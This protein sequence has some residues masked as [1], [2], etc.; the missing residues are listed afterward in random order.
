MKPLDRTKERRAGRL[1][2]APALALVLLAPGCSRPSEGST[3]RSA[4][5]AE[6]RPAAVPRPARLLLTG[7]IAASRSV[8]LFVPETPLW[9][10]QVRWLAEE[11]TSVKAGDPVAEFDSTA[12]ASQLEQ[13]RLA[14]DEARTEVARGE[15]EAEGTAAERAF[16][17]EGRRVEVEKARLDA[18]IPVEL[19]SRR[20]HEE[21]QLALRRAEAEQAKAEESLRAA[22]AAA[23]ADRKVRLLAEEK[24]RRDLDEAERA[25][26][27][28]TLRAPRDGVVVV[29]ENPRERRKIQE[30]DNVWP[31]MAV[32]KIPDLSALR[33][34]ANL[35]DVDDGALKAGVPAA[36]WPD[37]FPER[38]L[39]ARVASVAP[40]AQP[41]DNE[42]PRAAFKVLLDV[43]GGSLEGL[44]PGMSVRVEAPA[45]APGAVAGPAG[46]VEPLP[47]PDPSSARSVRVA[48]EDL[49]VSVDLK[50]TLAALDGEQ[51]GPTRLPNVWQFRISRMAP[52]GSKVKKGQPVL[53]F[54]TSE[55]VQSLAEKRAEGESARKLIEKRERDLE[56]R[57]KDL[58]LARAEA[59]ARR[60]KAALKADVPDEVVD[61]I[62]LKKARLDLALAV[63]EV[64]SVGRRLAAAERA[65][66]AELRILGS[67]ER[68]AAGR[69]AELEDA[70][71][72]MSIP[73]PRD[74]TVL[75]VPNWRDEKKKV[76]DSCWVGEKVLEVPDLSRL[77][78]KGEVDE[79][80]AGR[81]R[82]GDRVTVRLDAHPDV[83]Y[84][85]KVR[86]IQRTVQRASPKVPL[87]VARVEVALDAVDEQRMRPGM[88]VRGRVELERVRR[89]L[90]V[91]LDCV[92]AADG[93]PVV[94]R[95]K[96][97]SAS[98]VSVTLGRRGDGK[99]EVLSGLAEGD[100]VL[101][102]APATGSGEGA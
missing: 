20:D 48:R 38:R 59:E 37:A 47:G 64:E 3:A 16:A 36:V 40:V 76:G 74:G 66:A 10:V 27:A 31:G 95:K 2:L 85:G 93:G 65:A 88:R 70:I 52:E 35:F 44:R 61:E 19:R 22:R 49:T 78:V 83:A 45:P 73:A 18:A 56:L 14:W 43:T 60:R 84:E 32:V 24:A 62:S 97:S 92:A 33:V 94:F 23:D 29:A 87:K 86:L 7:E 46:A 89:A 28:L 82:E 99:V 13:R 81:V 11:G 71:R 98:A 51:I 50:G 79:A 91:P 21:K 54:D 57:R 12:L 39:P 9:M 75:Y 5:A 34:E 4:P 8:D 102:V 41:L 26:A 42:S 77:G 6:A 90:V 68:Q 69:V 58:E 17:V 80:D 101:A 100:V 67:R 53:S 25:V 55:L 30:G 96:G 63:R 15:A 1:L 72:K